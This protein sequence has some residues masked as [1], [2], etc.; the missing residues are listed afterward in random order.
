MFKIYI[1][2]DSNDSIRHT[3]LMLIAFQK[4]TDKD[5]KDNLG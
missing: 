1:E 2:Q 5:A 3:T 4:G